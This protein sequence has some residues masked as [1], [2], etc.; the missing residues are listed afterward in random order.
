MDIKI[1]FGECLKQFLLIREWTASRLAMEI[2]V[3]P[4]Y[5]R[6]WVRGERIPSIQSDYT[7]LI[8][9][10]LINNLDLNRQKPIF[11]SLFQ[12]LV[13]LGISDIDKSRPL[14]ELIEKV[15][16]D[17]QI[18][19]LSIKP[20]NKAAHMQRK[21]KLSL[22]IGQIED[23]TNF[24]DPESERD[25][26]SLKVADVP[27][28][29][30]G[31]YSLLCAVLS[32]LRASMNQ[33]DSNPG[34]IIITFQSDQHIFQGYHVAYRM[35]KE[36]ITEALKNKWEIQ[37]LCNVNKNT[38]RSLKLVEEIIE[39]A[40][41]KNYF[42][43]CFFTKFNIVNPPLEIIVIKK[44]GAFILMNAENGD[45][46]D[47]ALFFKQKDI[48]DTLYKY[49]IKMQ[50]DTN[51][52]LTYFPSFT[53]YVE[54]LALKCR[55][56]G[57]FFAVSPDLYFY[58]IPLSLWEKYITCTITDIDTRERHIKRIIE[59][60]RVF[61]EDVKK[62]KVKFI[63]QLEALEWMVESQGY[64][65]L[66]CYQKPTSEDILEH[67]EYTVHLLKTYENLEI[68][69]MS[70]NRNMDS[71]PAVAWEVRDNRNVGIITVDMENHSDFAYL[72]VTEETVA[73]TFCDYFQKIWD[74]ITPKYRDKEFV[75]SLLEEKA[76]YL[77]EKLFQSHL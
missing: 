11:D 71:L 27:S 51:S 42:L 68:A 2:N 48:I 28:C 19:S 65:C 69:L 44:V 36:L 16:K 34:E 5:V 59:L 13:H 7:H 45:N 37:Y 12:Y 1:S 76:Q 9:S 49:T 15:L 63:C 54:F 35:W 14:P 58:T 57:N 62:F 26:F 74:K 29:I 40:G 10:A 50:S 30:E 61:H 47:R 17:A 23:R 60:S 6:M 75:I 46:I 32:V 21:D 3:E 73:G 67:L 24:N 53:A 31:R 8:S 55:K 41:Y 18:C 56:Q 20:K 43:P 52:M 72:A 77:Q 70:E 25:T 66:Y 64:F 4:S 38:S 39:W 33:R 22:I